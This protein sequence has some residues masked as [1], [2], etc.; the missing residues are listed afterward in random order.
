MS[1]HGDPS[2]DGGRAGLGEYSTTSAAILHQPEYAPGV[3][4]TLLREPVSAVLVS[5]VR[6]GDQPSDQLS[7]A[8]GYI[9]PI[10]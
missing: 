8:L 2:N 1:R 10:A 4:P 7:T 5:M 6:V 9:S 3:N